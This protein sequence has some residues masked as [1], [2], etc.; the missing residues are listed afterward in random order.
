[1]GRERTS[2]PPMVQLCADGW[3][4]PPVRLAHGFGARWRGVRPTP[5]PIGVLM[6]TRSIHGFGLSYPIDFV[7]LDGHGVVLRIGVLRPRRVALVGRAVWMA[8]YPL[9]V[10][11]PPVGT[12]TAVDR[13][14]AWPA[15]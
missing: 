6:G 15:G 13:L 8:E 14:V 1:M 10:P 4:P 11:M 12:A 2:R 3:D 5:G 9:G 7:A